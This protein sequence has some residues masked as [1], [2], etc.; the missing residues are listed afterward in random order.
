MSDVTNVPIE[1]RAETIYIGASSSGVLTDIQIEHAAQVK[2]QIIDYLTGDL[3]ALSGDLLAFVQTWNELTYGEEPGFVGFDNDKDSLFWNKLRE[4]FQGMFAGVWTG[5]RSIWKLVVTDL[6]DA[7][8][9]LKAPYNA[10]ASREALQKFI[11]MGVLDES[12]VGEFEKLFGET[13]LTQ[14]LLP[15]LSVIIAGMETIKTIFNT[16]GGDYAKKLLSVFTPG[17]PTTDSLI[18][19][20]FIAPGQSDIIRKKLSQ[21]GLSE[22]DQNIMLA[23][24]LNMIDVNAIATLF[25]RKELTSDEVFQKMRQ[26]GYTD[27]LTEEILKTWSVIPPIQD[28][29]RMVDREAFDPAVVQYYNYGEDSG[30]LPYDAFAANGLSKEWVDKYWYA[31]WNTPSIQMGYEMFHR[32]IISEG[33]LNDL[34][35]TV[36]IPSWWR[37]K[38]V[39]MSYK[40]LTRVDVRRMYG[41]GVLTEQQVYESYL[42]LGYSPTNAQ[43]MTEF[44]IRYEQDEDRELTRTQIETYYRS[45]LIDKSQALEL[46]ERIG[47]ASDRADFFLTFQDYERDKEIIDDIIDNTGELFKGGQITYDQARDRLFN[48][49]IPTK[50]ISALFDKWNIRIYNDRKLPSKTDLDKFYKAGVI[51]I[52]TYAEELEKLGYP[53]RYVEM[54]TALAQG[55]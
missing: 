16:A 43:L 22:E 11:N 53:V 50:Q 1:D 46:L 28:I 27:D 51:T 7:I 25:L 55:V 19:L 49:N 44:T 6:V 14:M 18:R 21:N 2:Q 3:G 34:F 5:F 12:A 20:G 39:Q 31:H 42:D 26:I 47:Y 37:D 54:Y 52:E 13:K 41:M 24:S 30:M 29:L 9:E 36:E 40:V 17:A 33:E 45:N 35:K 38:M 48:Q 32:R 10:N 15:I 4:F 23:A 8:K